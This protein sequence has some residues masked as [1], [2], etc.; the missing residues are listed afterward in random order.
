MR[1]VYYW[2]VL[3]LLTIWF[4]FYVWVGCLLLWKSPS[5]VLQHLDERL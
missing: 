1:K 4:V 3:K 5:K 2:V